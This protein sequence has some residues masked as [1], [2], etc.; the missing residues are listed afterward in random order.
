M[1]IRYYFSKQ[2]RAIFFLLPGV[3]LILKF[4]LLHSNYAGYYPLIQ[5]NVSQFCPAV[6]TAPL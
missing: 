4:F 5:A 3:L 6:E 1:F 2:C